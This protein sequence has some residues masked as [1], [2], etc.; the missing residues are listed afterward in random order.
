MKTIIFL[1]TLC[2]IVWFICNRDFTPNDNENFDNVNQFTIAN[3]N[4]KSLLVNN[5]KTS[6]LPNNFDD[7]GKS[8]IIKEDTFSDIA[9][10]YEVLPIKSDMF[11]LEPSN[12]LDTSIFNSSGLTKLENVDH[13]TDQLFINNNDKVTST[14]TNK[15]NKTIFLKTITDNNK[16]FNYMGVA[17]NEYNNLYYLI[18]E[19]VNT[20]K[21]PNNRTYENTS[22]KLYDDGVKIN[23]QTL[24]TKEDL[25]TLYE[26]ILVKFNKDKN[27]EIVLKVSPRERILYNDA[28]YFSYGQFELGPLIV[29]KHEF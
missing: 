3:N 18:Y 11:L 26:Y 5:N 8:W 20:N 4:I 28:V 14:N 17:F 16:L 22:S 2:L 27:Y 29:K 23:I 19:H 21:V 15:L 12:Q 1:I 25:F 9:N 13:N 7:E 10:N 24:K 6:V